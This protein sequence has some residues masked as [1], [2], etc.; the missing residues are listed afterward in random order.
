MDFALHILLMFPANT[1]Y[2]GHVSVDS[3]VYYN[4]QNIWNWISSLWNVI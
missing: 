2:A 3:A 1:C 4:M